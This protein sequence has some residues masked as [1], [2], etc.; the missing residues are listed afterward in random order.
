MPSRS[1]GERMQSLGHL[2]AGDILRYADHELIEV[3]EDATATSHQ[4]DEA[5]EFY[6]FARRRLNEEEVNMHVPSL[7]SLTSVDGSWASPPISSW[8]LPSVPQMVA[9]PSFLGYIDIDGTQLKVGQE[10]LSVNCLDHTIGNDRK[11]RIVVFDRWSDKMVGVDWENFNNQGDTLNSMIDSFSGGWVSPN[12]LRTIGMS[13]CDSC[14]GRNNTE[15]HHICSEVGRSIICSVCYD[16]LPMCTNCH[17]IIIGDENIYEHDTHIYCSR[18]HHNRE[19]SEVREY[20]HNY[21]FKPRATFFSTEKMPRLTYI[22]NTL[23]MGVEL[24]VDTQRGSKLELAKYMTSNS[25]NFL[26]LKE[27][28]SISKG[29]EIVTH[30][31]TLGYH[32]EKFG[33]HKHLKYL[34]NNGGRSHNVSNCGIHV[35]V[36]RKFFTSL[37]VIKVGLFVYT[38]QDEMEKL[39]RRSSDDWCRFTKKETLKD[40]AY[41]YDRHEALNFQNDF[42]IEFRMFRGT[43]KLETF[44]A[45]LQLV[46]AIS[47][48]IKTVGSPVLVDRKR[49]WLLF[50]DYVNK[51]RK[52]Y[53][54]LCAYIIERKGAVV[55]R[56]E[57]VRDDCCSEYDDHMYEIDD[58]Y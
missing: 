28:S 53:K 5:V 39:A 32:T 4:L 54:E 21:S 15:Y 7:G 34:R 20:I 8:D 18:C 11:G 22:P 25:R 19:E 2:T 10:V 26:Y 41:N 42:S 44:N 24:E 30:P 29:F 55:K 51:N 23:Y 12:E 14:N 48:F 31:A 40:H 56:E 9:P 47:R 13:I 46:D 37:E 36:S 1:L 57:S 35:H 27:D 50:K 43:L 38:Q 45:T 52:T 6:E 16:N 49:S 58:S 33:W 17:D 3:Q